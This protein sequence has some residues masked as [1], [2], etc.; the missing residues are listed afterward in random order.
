MIRRYIIWRNKHACDEQLRWVVTQAIAADAALTAC[1]HWHVTHATGP[2]MARRQ[3]RGDLKH[4]RT[5][6]AG[7]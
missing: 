7:D 5:A 3:R 1:R 6:A 4:M 2:A